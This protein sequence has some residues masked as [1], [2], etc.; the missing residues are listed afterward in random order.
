MNWYKIAQQI[1]P[2]LAA[3][4][5]IASVKNPNPVQRDFFFRMLRNPGIKWEDKEDF[6]LFDNKATKICNGSIIRNTPSRPEYL[7]KMVYEKNRNKFTSFEISVVTMVDQRA[8]FTIVYDKNQR[9]MPFDDAIKKI[10]SVFKIGWMSRS[11]MTINEYLEFRREIE[12]KEN[13]KELERARELDEEKKAVDFNGIKAYEFTR[14]T[15]IKSTKYP[16]TVMYIFIVKNKDFKDDVS[17]APAFSLKNLETDKEVPVQLIREYG[18][19]YVVSRIAKERAVE[20]AMRERGYVKE[21]HPL[22]IPVEANKDNWNFAENKWLRGDVVEEIEKIQEE[23]KQAEQLAQSAP[24]PEVLDLDTDTDTDTLES[25]I[26]KSKPQPRRKMFDPFENADLESNSW[27]K[28]KKQSQ[29]AIEQPT[30]FGGYYSGNIPEYAERFIGTPSVDAS[31]ISGAFRGTS[32]AIQLVNSYSGELLKNIA[33]IFNFSKGGAFGVYVPSLDRAIKTNLLKSKLEQK[34]YTIKEEN[35]TL[36]AYPKDEQADPAKITEEIDAQ[37]KQIEDIGGTIIGLNAAAITSA[38]SKNVNFITSDL[39]SQD[40]NVP[41]D[42]SQML[43]EILGIYHLAATIVHEAAHSKGAMDEAT[44]EAEEAK[45]RQWA[46]STYVNP[47]YMKRLQNAKLEK[48]YT[49]LSVGTEAIHAQTKNWYKVAQFQAHMNG[50]VLSGQPSGSDLQGRHNSQGNQSASPDWSM[51][52]TQQGNEPMDQRLDIV[53]DNR[54]Y[55][56]PDLSQRNDIIEEQLRKQTRYDSKP[57]TKLIMEEL[58]EP[59]RDENVAYT[60]LEMLLENQRPRPLMVPISKEEKVEKV[61]SSSSNNPFIRQARKAGDRFLF[62][63]FNNLDISDGSTIPGLGDRVMAWDDR[64]E[65]FAWSDQD[66]RSQPRYNPEYDLKGFYYRWIEPRF[67][68][69][70]FDDMTRDYANTSPAKRFAGQLDPEIVKILQIVKLIEQSLVNDKIK[71]TRIVT[72]KIVSEFIVKLMPK[73]AIKIK[74]Y[75]IVPKT[76]DGWEDA[77]AIWFFNGTVQEDVINKCEDYFQDKDV[78]D[79]ARETTEGIVGIKEKRKQNVE[80]VI[81]KAREICVSI[82]CKL[83]LIGEYPRKVYLEDKT[84]V[85]KLEFVGDSP[86]SCQ[87]VGYMLME[88]LGV[89]GEDVYESARFGLSFVFKGIQVDFSKSAYRPKMKELAKS[90]SPEVLKSALVRSALN[91]DFTINT[92]AFNIHNTSKTLS[93]QDVLGRA[94]EDIDNKVLR[95]VLNADSVIKINPT[96]I[97]RAIVHKMNGYELDK[98]LTTAIIVNA[99]LIMQ[100]RYRAYI[101][102]NM[103]DL[104]KGN[105]EDLYNI[106]KNLRLDGL[107][108]QDQTGEK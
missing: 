11:F 39:K 19:N 56:A 32:E 99:K 30:D 35:G 57:N 91:K 46:Q 108:D 22:Y 34:G 28:M 80:T 27:Y 83:Y 38:V 1:S 13:N 87:K 97:V 75:D 96:I 70:L 33:F 93:K 9:E 106:L 53:R 102:N 95:T 85:S 41:N 60:S 16:A 74:I 103:S 48:Y 12:E 79:E 59:N 8:I 42:V 54:Q 71:A 73:E 65:D 43:T 47:E 82:N 40:P 36:V 18:P 86:D 62:G 52:M 25:P 37:W 23:H 29:T 98:E 24:V 90:I 14:L 72:N 67:K 51:L 58:L 78:S 107:L 100:E 10:L 77:C 63:W 92:L 69:Q 61:K 88:Q 31:Q 20:T 66:I 15:R 6:T 104:F 101:N 64:D 45:F 105:K 4:E 49:P 50:S 3:I 44:A 55:L 81:A 7:L 21:G 68:P 2:E 84:P 26:E 89:T 5:S 76:V 17:S 94:M